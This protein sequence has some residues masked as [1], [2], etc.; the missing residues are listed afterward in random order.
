VSDFA[1]VSRDVVPR[2][3]VV[4]SP[5]DF[6]SAW[7]DRPAS[8]VAIGLRL[9]STGVDE[10]ARR[11]AAR[12]AWE[13]VPRAE[14]REARYEQ[15]GEQVIR[16]IVAKAT[17]NPNNVDVPYFEHA[18]ET[19]KEALTSRGVRKVFDAYERLLIEQGALD[20]AITDDDIET[21]ARLLSSGALRMLAPAK[22]IRARKLLSFVRDELNEG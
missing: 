16:W 3:T 8:P 15:Y 1:K 17:C 5:D 14:D 18:E 12:L 4:L 2:A 9:I 19:I 22:E 11:E 20:E 21:L 6:A 10:T 7:E 13:A